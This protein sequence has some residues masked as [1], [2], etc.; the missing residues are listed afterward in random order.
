MHRKILTGLLFLIIFYHLIFSQSTFS[1][2]GYYKNY[3]TAIDLPKYESA[4]SPL[5]INQ[6]P[7]VWV[8]NRL[9]L[10]I[11]YRIESNLSFTLAYDFSP[12]IQDPLLFESQ[13]ILLPVDP[14]SYRFVDFNRRPVYFNY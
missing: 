12:R 13:P 3:F 11:F 4:S 6:P 7:L 2:N 1:I 9:R 8:N 10:N 5:V 14:S